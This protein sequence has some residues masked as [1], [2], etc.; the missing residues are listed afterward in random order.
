MT[1]FLVML[2]LPNLIF[3]ALFSSDSTS[4]NVVG[5]SASAVT[6]SASDLTSTSPSTDSSDSEGAFTKRKKKI[7][8]N[9]TYVINAHVIEINLYA[10]GWLLF[11][12]LF[13][14]GSEERLY[15]RHYWGIHSGC[16]IDSMHQRA[17]LCHVS[18]IKKDW[19][20]K[21][22]F[23]MNEMTCHFYLKV[24]QPRLNLQEKNSSVVR[25]YNV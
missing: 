20:S 16:N 9:P 25:S 6:T 3:P 21:S 24:L 7:M 4:L 10:N 18:Q 5:P 11:T 22:Q 14:R 15:S 1:H 13:L 23:I 12:L 8:Q 19:F 2:I 17:G